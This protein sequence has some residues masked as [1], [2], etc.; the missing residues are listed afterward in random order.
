MSLG[1]V[2]GLLFGLMGMLGM[3]MLTE[4]NTRRYIL[5]GAVVGSMAGVAALFVVFVAL[6]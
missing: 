1:F 2:W 4:G 6:Y 5:E 3:V